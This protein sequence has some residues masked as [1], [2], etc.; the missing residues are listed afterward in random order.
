[1]HGA[2]A[3]RIAFTQHGVA[4]H[5]LHDR[6]WFYRHGDLRRIRATTEVRLR[7]HGVGRRLGRARQR[8]ADIGVAQ[9][10]HRAPLV[11]I[12]R[13]IRVARS[14]SVQSHRVEV[15]DRFVGSR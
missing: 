3:D 14:G 10:R 12:V 4:G 5:R 7:R 2:Q 13:R 9:A 15:T 11:G 6:S 8:L 1:M